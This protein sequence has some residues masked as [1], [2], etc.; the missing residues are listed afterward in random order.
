MT[1]ALSALLRYAPDGIRPCIYTHAD[2]AADRP[3]YVALR[4]PRFGIPFYSEMKV[5]LPRLRAL[6]ARVKADGADLIHVTTPGPVGLPALY[7]A[8]R[9][10]LPMVGS[11]HTDLGSY[12]RILSG[13]RSGRAVSTPCSS[14][15]TAGPSRCAAR[16]AWSEARS[17][18]CTPAG[19]RRKKGWTCCPPWRRACTLRVS[20]NVVLEAQATGLPVVVA[21]RGGPQENMRADWTGRIC[22]A[23][24]SNDFADAI[25]EIA[26]D[27]TRLQSMSGDARRY[28]ESR[29][30]ED[31]LAPLYRA[32]RNV[33]ARQRVV[34]PVRPVGMHGA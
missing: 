32:Y 14:R 1:T 24:R 26:S 19:Y 27:S 28:A 15:R 11:F 3:G 21:D 2:T 33:A 29:R 31:A 6:R 23:D 34:Y 4:A 12:V 10:R 9:L 30:W 8:S 18:C 7:V 25:I 13:S 22:R 16:G 20:G 17:R 5:Y